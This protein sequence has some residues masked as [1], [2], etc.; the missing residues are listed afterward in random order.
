MIPAILING[1]FVPKV[2]IALGSVIIVGR[3]LYRY[4]YMTNQG[5]NSHIRE[6]GAVPLN[7]AEISLILS[8]LVICS[9]YFIG[10]FFGRRRFIQRFT[11]S[12]MDI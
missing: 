10:P 4:G 2:T 1:L 11:K 9:R 5:P 7:I 12:S 6:L 8:M 3:E